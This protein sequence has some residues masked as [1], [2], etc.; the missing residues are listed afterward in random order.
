MTIRGRI[1]QATEAVIGYDLP[2]ERRTYCCHCHT[3]VTVPAR[4]RHAARHSWVYEPA[5][6]V[7]R[8]DYDIRK[9]IIRAQA[10]AVAEGG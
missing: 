2:R 1:R 9:L 3:A 6:K 4:H 7:A 5:K 8:S 10:T